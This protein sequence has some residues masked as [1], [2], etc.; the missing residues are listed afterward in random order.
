LKQNNKFFA[1]ISLPGIIYL[2]SIV[3]FPI[4]FT[5]YLSFHKYNF[6]ETPLSNIRWIGLGNYITI[7]KDS[8][9]WNSTLNTGIYLVVGVVVELV[10]GLGIALLIFRL[11]K[12]QNIVTSLIL[13]PSMMAPIVIGLVFRFMFN[14][15]FGVFDFILSKMGL[16]VAN[17]VLGNRS[18]ALLGIIFADI[19]QWTPFI[20]I[21]ILSG[22]I[23]LPH[24]PFEAARI[25][26]ANGLEILTNI[27]LPLLRPV[28]TV[29]ILIRMADIVR[30]FDKI[31]VMTYGGPGAAS[32]VLNFTA[33]RINYI[34]FDM[35]VGSAYVV[36]I[37]AI[38]ILL[39]VAVFKTFYVNEF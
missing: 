30:E 31:F 16:V 36:V 6:I 29:A 25:D 22:L 28:L 14:P 34:N 38:V 37:F 2:L 33:Y 4:I 5:V 1:L 10:I 27:T 13:L 15:Q 24:E 26:G 23:A 39:S 35:G 18:T 7:F 3:L 20:A 9:F 11:F 32:E 19:W 17:S 21:I 12:N 8:T